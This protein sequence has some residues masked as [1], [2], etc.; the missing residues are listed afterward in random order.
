MDRVL[1]FGGGL[2]VL[3]M[4]RSL[5][6]NGHYV[7][8]M[9]EHNEVS[10]KC[11]FVERCYQCNLQEQ[12]VGIFL[13]FISDKNYEIVI[14][15]EDPYSDWLSK[16]KA[17]IEKL[18]AIKC[19]V[20]DWDIYQLASDKTRLLAFCESKGIPHPKTML[21]DENLDVVAG[22]I[23]FPALV[24]P[25]HSNGA[26][27]IVKVDDIEQFKT[28]APKIKA[29]YG[30]CTLQEYIYTKDYYYNVMLY[31]CVDGK[32]ANHCIIKILRYYPIKG[33]SSSLCMTVEN[34][35]L[36]NICKKTLNELQWIG[37]ADLDLLE[38]SDGDYRLI[39][40]NPR[41]PAS[42]KASAISGVNFAEIIVAGTLGREIPKYVYQTGK[43]L[44]GIGLDIAWFI[45]SPNR[46][47]VKPSWFKFLGR[48]MYYM[49][50][51]WK[52][53]KAMLMSIWIGIKKQ[54]NPNFRKEKSG[55]N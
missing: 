43:Y 2:Q 30:E 32:F 49:E 18:S 11:C 10:C 42:V 17:E 50:G 48:D 24:K 38:K 54:M 6:E 23:G 35:R 22:K 26:R 36:L 13:D 45:A 52:D 29:K 25:S 44:R 20:M 1:L 15:M 7:D 8:V 5:K 55:M 12:T 53:I 41:V 28:I 40:I 46:F 19:A 39:E 9:G 4:A 16:N 14:P 37:F 31:R 21:I 33:G 51:G 3:S 47:R 34:E 27:G